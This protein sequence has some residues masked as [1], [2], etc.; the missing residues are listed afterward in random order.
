VEAEAVQRCEVIVVG[1]GPAGTGTVLA[2]ARRAPRLAAGTLVLEKAHHPRDKTCAGG[3]IPK[4]HGLLAALGVSADVPHARV[5]AA[6]VTVPGGCVRI[7]GTEL[8]RVVRRREF[9]AALARAAAATGATIVQNARVLDVRREGDGV[10]VQTETASYWTPIVVGADGSGSLVRRRL[11][12]GPAGPVARAVMCDVAVSET[13]WDGF[14]GRRYDFD[15]LGIARGMRGYG[16]IFPSVIEGIPHAN[17]GVYALPPYDAGRMEG[18][19]VRLLA[20]IGVAGTPRRRAF[21]IHTYAPGAR[22]AAPNALLVG[23]AAGVDPLM[24]EGISFALEYGC[25]AAEAIVSAAASGRLDVAGYEAA[26]HDGPIGRKLARLVWATERGYGRHWRVW[27]RLAR[28]SRR[29]RQ[30]ALE[31]YNG[32]APWEGRGRLALARALVR[33]PRKVAA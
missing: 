20:G 23:D 1:A 7:G 30:A 25:V 11:V 8:C 31:W 4:T 10:R 5:D 33:A 15:F 26:I 14:A 6:R 29:A 21:P 3:L 22:L 19:L 32:V 24:G 12:G 27:F 2:L 9:D 17:V 18:E 28:S 16:W 13:T